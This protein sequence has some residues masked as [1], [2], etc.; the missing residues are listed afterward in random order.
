MGRLEE[1]LSRP[2]EQVIERNLKL[3]ERIK[4][5]IIS[6]HGEE[7]YRKLVAAIQGDHDYDKAEQ[8]L[9]SKRAEGV[10]DFGLPV[11]S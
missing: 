5:K 3:I 8:E 6:L 4:D 10:D 9:I 11:L 2:K 7:H 1:F